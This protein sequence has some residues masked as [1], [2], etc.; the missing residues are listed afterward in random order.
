MCSHNLVLILL[1]TV[2]I[3]VHGTLETSSALELAEAPQEK[4]KEVRANFGLAWVKP[5]NLLLFGELAFT[6][7]YLHRSD[8]SEFQP[9]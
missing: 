2:M 6:Y 3:W 8:W 4:S 7:L 1:T 5:K 9:L